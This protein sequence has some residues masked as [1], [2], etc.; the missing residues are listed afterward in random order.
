MNQEKYT[1]YL[2]HKEK[3]LILNNSISDRNIEIQKTTNIINE[4]KSLIADIKAKLAIE[5]RAVENPSRLRPPALSAEQ[6]LAHKGNAERFE[7]ELPELNESLDYL[8]RSLSI[9]QFDLSSAQRELDHIKDHLAV[10]LVRQ[11]I[12]ELVA[13][14]SEPIKKLVNAIMAV[15]RK[16]KGFNLG[17][18][19]AFKVA[20]YSLICEQLLPP[21]FSGKNELPDLHEANQYITAIIEATE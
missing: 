4:N 21:I 9:L 17:E 11:S 6:Y 15:E 16:S 8:N 13:V 20:T 5:D 18:K 3:I 10:Y 2:E 14:A 19:E 7:S 1:Q 12:D